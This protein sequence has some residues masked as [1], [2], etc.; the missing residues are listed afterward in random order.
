MGEEYGE[1]APFQ[2]F[3]DHIDPEIAKATREGRRAEFA[4]FASFN[5]EVPDPQDV[6]TFERSKLTRRRDEALAGLYAELLSV[7]RELAPGEARGIEFDEGERWLRLTRG[8]FELICNF[9]AATLTLPCGA[10]AIRIATSEATLRDGSIELP[11][12]SGALV[13]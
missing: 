3:S 6:A 4:A 1:E 10:S 11:A 12:L 9:S 5:E 8:G 7:R 13:R 2:F